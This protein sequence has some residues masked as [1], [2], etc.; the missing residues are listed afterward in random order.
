MC[1]HWFCCVHRAHTRVR[2]TVLVSTVTVYLMCVCSSVP[3]ALYCV[4]V[5]CTQVYLRYTYVHINTCTHK[6]MQPRTSKLTHTI[7]Y[8]AHNR[9]PL[10]ARAASSPKTSRL[11]CWSRRRAAQRC[12][13]LFRDSPCTSALTVIWTS[14]LRNEGTTK[15]H[16]TI[17]CGEICTLRNEKFHNET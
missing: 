4:Y 9:S 8:T 3:H 1:I 5:Y 14:R 12:T 7:H 17:Q 2:I 10:G 16:Y 6:H 15:S 13:A 11:V